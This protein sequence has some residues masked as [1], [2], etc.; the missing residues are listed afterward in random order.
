M[1]NR[2]KA[3]E[4][5]REAADILERNEDEWILPGW[6]PDAETPE[7]WGGAAHAERCA[8]I[9]EAAHAVEAKGV[10]IDHCTKIDVRK[11]GFLARYIG[12]ILE[13]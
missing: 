10:G 8:G 4:L 1:T 11:L 13:E 3:I 2:E 9:R 5:L 6:D 7:S 12:D